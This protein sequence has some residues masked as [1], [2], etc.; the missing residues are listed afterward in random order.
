MDFFLLEILIVP[1]CIYGRLLSL[2]EYKKLFTGEEGVDVSF[3][4]VP[5]M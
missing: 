2:Q 4:T 1:S 5:V 3:T